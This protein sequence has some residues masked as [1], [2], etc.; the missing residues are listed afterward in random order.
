MK[1]L[2]KKPSNKVTIKEIVIHVGQIIINKDD[3]EPYRIIDLKPNFK[4]IV[5]KISDN[6][7]F[8]AELSE[9]DY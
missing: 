4:L 1:T 5:K 6:K 7:L 2:K 3:K 8:T 9:F